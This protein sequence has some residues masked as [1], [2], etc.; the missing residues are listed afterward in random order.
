MLT[1]IWKLTVFCRILYK[2]KN[3]EAP[4]TVSADLTKHERKLQDHGYTA[5]ASHSVSV[6]FPVELILI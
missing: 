5:N 1:F 4:I 3:K 6:Y 2:S